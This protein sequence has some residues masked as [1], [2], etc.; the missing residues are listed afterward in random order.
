MNKGVLGYILAFSLG[1]AAGSVVSWRL[2]KNKYAQLAEEEIASVKEVFSRK[3]TVVNEEEGSAEDDSAPAPQPVEEGLSVRD[4]AAKLA[5]SGYTNYSD[6]QRD[7]EYVEPDTEVYVISPEEFG[8]LDEYETISLTYYAPDRIL[9]D[10]MDEIIEDVDDVVGAGSLNR[11]GE[12]E[13][14][15]VFVRNER[16]RCDYEI[17][18][19]SRSYREVVGRV[20]HQ[21]EGE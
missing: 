5:K 6:I 2:L 4:Y 14:D 7:E 3:K 10:D 21:A 20:P 1:A 16:M 12:Y 18:L 11:F 17:L 8:E 19:D 13:D 9:A 15:S